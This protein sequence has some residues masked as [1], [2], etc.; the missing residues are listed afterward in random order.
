V[1]RLAHI[2]ALI[3]ALA[4]VTTACGGDE[5]TGLPSTNPTATP[6]DHVTIVD[7]AFEPKTFEILVNTEARWVQTGAL[8]HSVTADDGSFTSH[9]ACSASDTSQCMKTGGEFKHLFTNAGTFPYHC[10]IHGGKGGSGMSGVIIV[11]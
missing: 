5:G 8:P 3:A 2:L 9:P 4:F 10:L 6:S 1:R 11:K 7:S